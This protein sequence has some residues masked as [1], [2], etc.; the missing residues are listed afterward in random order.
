MKAYCWI[1]ICLAV[2]LTANTGCAAIATAPSNSI[3]VE[4]AK[5]NSFI[6]TTTSNIAHSST[7]QNSAS[8]KEYSIGLKLFTPIWST[9]LGTIFGL[10]VGLTLREIILWLKRK[11]LTRNL[12]IEI[13]P[14]HGRQFRCRIAN[15]G[16]S[17][18]KNAVIYIALKIEKDDTQTPPQD[19]D[20]IIR[21]D[22]FVPLE[23]DPLCW[24]VRA[25]DINPMKVD[26]YAKERQPFSPC[27]LTGDDKM[28][29]IPTEEGW[30]RFRDDKLKMRVFLR[31]KSY[32]GNLK[33]VSEN[34]NARFFKI[35]IDASENASASIQIMP[36]SEKECEL[37]I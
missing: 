17:T 32:S 33:V 30:P 36:I 4:I 15:G 8:N 22:H 16:S 23:G 31:R 18:I 20:A 27:A 13:E 1:I 6:T 26:I 12:K 35:T 19:H 29:M 2:C 3:A 5:T 10:I 7:N 34:T 21:P 25:P 37:K 28:L 14:I 24:S 9:F 11:S